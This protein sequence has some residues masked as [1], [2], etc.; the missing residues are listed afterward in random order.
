MNL[1][2]TQ[3]M[4]CLV[5]TIPPFRDH[6]K[7]WVGGTAWLPLKNKSKKWILPRHRIWTIILNLQINL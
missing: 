4:A 6:A 1:N 7:D 2:S 5:M 3:M